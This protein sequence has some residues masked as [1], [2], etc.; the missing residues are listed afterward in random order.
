MN[1]KILFTLVFVLGLGY[2]SIKAQEI[3]NTLSGEMIFSWSD[4]NYNTPDNGGS[5]MY[6]N[7][8]G[9]TSDAL[10][11]TIWFHLYSYWHFDFSEKFGL[12]TGIGNRNIGLITYESS[13][14]KGESLNNF[15]NVKWK[16]RSYALGA[17]L[18]FKFGNLPKDIYFYAGAQIEWLYHY[19]EK[20]FL[21]TGKRK[22]TEWFSNKTNTFLPSA[23][24]GISLPSGLNIKFTYAL[25]DFM[26]KTYTNP[27][28]LQPYK[29]MDSKIMY[30]SISR[31]M[32]WKKV[33]Y[34]KVEKK[35]NK[36]AYL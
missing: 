33:T 35:E 28:G 27:E 6:G 26:N 36:I 15:Y 29:F 10:R 7:V 1:K 22:S 14:V 5:L 11:F 19:K 16:R 13:S 3:Y 2:S 18:A 32:R 4:A 12:Y 17:P 31:P 30:I 8:A 34:D 25:D 21:T 24:V 9:E 23:F 20:E